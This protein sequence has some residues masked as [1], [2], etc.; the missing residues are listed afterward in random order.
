MVTISENQQKLEEI[1]N[2]FIINNNEPGIAN[3][4][5]GFL[6]KYFNTINA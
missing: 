1:I 2:N 4:I 6:Y 5:P 3:V